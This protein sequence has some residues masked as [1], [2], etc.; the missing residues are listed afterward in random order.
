MKI[1]FYIN[2]LIVRGNPSFYSGAIQ[3]KMI[4]QAKLLHGAGHEI[5]FVVSEFDAES[6]IN[7]MPD[8]N[9]IIIGSREINLVLG[10]V[11]NIEKF[12]YKNLNQK[13]LVKMSTLIKSKAPASV[14]VV[15]AWETPA[16]LF[17]QLYPDAK[18]I[19][20]MPGFLSRIPFP[21]LYTLDMDGLFHESMLVKHI[22]TIRALPA[23]PRAIR[24]L[25]AVR[26]E[27]VSFIAANTP[28]TRGQLD[29]LG[30]FKRLILLPLQVTD[31]YAFLVDSGYESQMALLMDVLGRTPKNIGVVVTQYANASTE[32]RVLNQERY[33][34]L[35]AIY[36]NLIFDKTF[37]TLDN[38]SQYLLSA[39]DAVVTVSS[40]IGTQALLWNKPLITLGN[41]HM[42]SLATHPTIADYATAIAQGIDPVIDSDN[43]LA[44]MLTYQQPL[45]SMILEDGN[46][47]ERWLLAL[48]QGDDLLTLPNFFDLEPDSFISKSPILSSLNSG[49]SIAVPE[50]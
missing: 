39:V 28:F 44:W 35:K 42:A 24:L 18:V 4:P 36:P 21:E 2:P 27:L 33:L 16:N 22:D 48:P 14:D 6:V 38:I 30:Q 37:D 29:P 26:T 50:R 40:S 15:F 7:L 23:D 43:I 9:V 41:S 47:L 20:Q 10:S 25:E 11:N 31:Q 19:H 5:T 49:K 17:R 13:I 8:I 34:Q 46:F 3:K 1:L 45:A 32:E 12:L